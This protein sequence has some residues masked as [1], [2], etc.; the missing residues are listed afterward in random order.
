LLYDMRDRP[1]APVLAHERD[2]LAATLHAKK[3]AFY[4]DLVAG[5]SVPLRPGVERLM[6]ECLAQGVRLGIVT[7]TSRSNVD[8]LL[9]K[10]LGREWARRFAVIVCGEDVE[11]KKPDPEVYQIALARLEIG[12]L[13]AVAVEDSP[14]GVAAANAADVPVMVTR[15]AYFADATVES[16]IAIGPGLHSRAEWRPAAPAGDG[17]IGLGDITY[18]WQRME[19]VSAL[20]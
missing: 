6:H 1:D 15:S 3:N 16:A 4:A 8:A 12:P 2:A 20:E 10:H 14:G 11:R 5:G 9:R 7:T 19:L 13:E 18:W 17:A